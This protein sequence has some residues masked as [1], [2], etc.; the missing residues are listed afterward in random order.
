MKVRDDIG[1][2]ELLGVTVGAIV[3]DAW[4]FGDS[5]DDPGRRWTEQQLD[6]LIDAGL[7]ELFMR[8][9]EWAKHTYVER[10]LRER[11][12]MAALRNRVATPEVFLHYG[13]IPSREC[14]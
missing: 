3:V 10:Q 6:E 11:A 9:A 12:A 2:P 1:T 4:L 14:S 13:R 8:G 5:R 7:T